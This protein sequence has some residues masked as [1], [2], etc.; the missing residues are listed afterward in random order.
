QQGAI[1][2]DLNALKQD[3][4][5]NFDLKN[6]F[7]SAAPDVA[8]TPANFA[9][10]ADYAKAAALSQLT[11]IDLSSF[12]NPGDV[13]QAGKAPTVLGNFNQAQAGSDIQK[14]LAQQD[15]SWIQ[16]HPLPSTDPAYKAFQLDLISRN[17]QL[18]QNNTWATWHQNNQTPN[19]G[20]GPMLPPA[21]GS[22]GN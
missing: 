15:T 7:N 8:I 3:Y 14:A 22:G 17:P 20:I 6:Y 12:L 11:G 9:T 16:N 19:L 21:P 2:S 10:P 18:L 13:T 4:G 1:N 5:Q